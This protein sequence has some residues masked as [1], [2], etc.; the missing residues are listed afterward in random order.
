MYVIF[1]RAAPTIR[2]RVHELLDHDAPACTF[3]PR[4]SKENGVNIPQPE[5][6]TDT[7]DDASVSSWL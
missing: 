1:S 6:Q 4:L 3:M 5:P 7:A 2:T